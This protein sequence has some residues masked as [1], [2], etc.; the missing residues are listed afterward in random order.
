V[1]FTASPSTTTLGLSQVAPT[2]ALRLPMVHLD[3]DL[4]LNVLHTQPQKGAAQGTVYS[5]GNPSTQPQ[6]IVEGEA[7]DLG[8]GCPLASY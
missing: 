5:Q 1:P 3:L 6:F 4:Y 2:L 8:G 7:P